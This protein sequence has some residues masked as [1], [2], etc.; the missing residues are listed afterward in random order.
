[1]RYS[2]K[3]NAKVTTLAAEVSPTDLTVTLADATGWPDG[4]IGPFWGSANKG[5]LTE[6][7]ILFS[8]RSGNVLQVFTDTG[9][10]GRGMDDTIAQ[11]HPINSPIEHVW[12]ATEADAAS[13]HIADMDG[14]HGYPPASNVVTLDGSQHITG[15]KTM[16]SPVLHTPSVDGIAA[17]GGTLV[18]LTEVA[19]AK[20]VVTGAQAEAEF[21][22]R[23][24]YIG[25]GAPSN[26]LGNDGD[27]YID[28]G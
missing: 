11:T 3:G 26:S 14:A 4:S 2:H 18:D 6:E 10:N 25:I 12:T 19:S 7:K 1:M 20:A 27:I 13:A 17:I 23:N 28:K 9:G 5:S 8:G 24:T 21:R 16:D 15:I 22:V